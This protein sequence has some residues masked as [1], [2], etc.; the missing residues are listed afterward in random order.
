MMNVFEVQLASTIPRHRGLIYRPLE[1]MTS[2]RLAENGRHGM[3]Y[4]E[5]HYLRAYMRH[6][7]AS[8]SWAARCWCGVCYRVMT[9][10]DDYLE[11]K[12]ARKLRQIA[13]RKV[14]APVPDA[15]LT[16]GPGCG[17]AAEPEHVSTGLAWL[18]CRKTQRAPFWYR[19]GVLVAM[20]APRACGR[21]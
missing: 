12:A 3:L 15:E 11:A 6:S 18:T 20:R 10:E 16:A 5:T 13:L 7:I 2:S 17:S 19:D 8:A 9:D 21:R 14:S 1:A 4:A